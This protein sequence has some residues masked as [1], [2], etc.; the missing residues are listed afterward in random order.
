EDS[1]L[2]P[3]TR[4]IVEAAKARRIPANRLDKY[5]LVQLG[6]GSKQRR[7]R[8]AETDQTGAIAQSI[9]QDKD[10]TRK[11]LQSAGV[12][13]PVGFPVANAADAWETATDWVGLPVVVK[14]QDGNQ[15]KGVTTNLSTQE[16]VYAAYEAAV[17]ISPSVIVEK[18][19]PGDDYR[20]LV[21]GG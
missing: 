21:I 11:L 14:P 10:L 18:Y 2:G 8:A 3:S 4:S 20:M 7:I 12:P 15:G 5:S 9:A 13:T 1:M 17:A 6:H 16:A 19:A